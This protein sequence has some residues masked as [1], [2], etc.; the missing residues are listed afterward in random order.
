MINILI[1]RAKNRTEDLFS[2]DSEQQWKAA[3]PSTWSS[4]GGYFTSFNP[5]LLVDAVE[6]CSSL[7]P[8]S[9]IAVQC[10]KQAS[11][12]IF[13]QA[14]FHDFLSTTLE[15]TASTLLDGYS[16]LCSKSRLSPPGNFCLQIQSFIIYIDNFLSALPTSGRFSTANVGPVSWSTKKTCFSVTSKDVNGQI[17]TSGTDKFTITSSGTHNNKL[18][19]IK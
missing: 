19:M 6:T 8:T 4:N 10:E 3:N 11:S 2:Y 1:G 5:Q 17:V 12:K 16:R 15:S 14:C 9:S 18:Y 7:H 13:Y